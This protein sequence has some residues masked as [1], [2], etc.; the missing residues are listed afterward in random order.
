MKSTG[1]RL[2]VTAACV[3][4][5]AGSSGLLSSAQGA[6]APRQTIAVPA[7]IYPSD[8]AW[9]KLHNPAPGAGLIVA[10]PAS[11]PGT[12]RDPAYAEAI[13]DAH[14]AGKKVIGYVDTGYFGTTGWAVPGTDDSSTS[15]WMDAVKENVDSWYRLYGDS[16]V[17]GIF[18]DDALNDCGPSSGSTA[19]VD[20]Y[21]EI[22]A[23]V[24][25]KD[26]AAHVAANPGTHP[27]E[28]YADAADTLVTFEGSYAQYEDWSP[29]SWE[30]A[31]APSKIWHLVYET[32]QSRMPGAISL[33]KDRNAG[34]VYVTDDDNTP[35]DGLPWGN[36]WDTLPPDAYWSAEVA[37]AGE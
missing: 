28:C 23:Y 15:A 31:V 24:K 19:H 32:D 1:R 21:E 11:G 36:P 14:D 20:L 18:F 17:G 37:A 16:G 6:A 3:V 10:N 22:Q 9:G 4:L 2:A 7:Y 8:N 34:Y 27:D 33:S 5:A 13:R 30:T 29:S 35:V 25:S 12:G 26:P